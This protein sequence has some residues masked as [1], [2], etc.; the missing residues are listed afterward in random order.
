[1]PTSSAYT[2][3]LSSPFLVFPYLAEGGGGVLFSINDDIAVKTVWNSDNITLEYVEQQKD[4]IAGIKVESEIYNLLSKPENRHPNILLSFL[5][6]PDY[7]FLERLPGSL[8]D[9]MSNPQSLISQKAQHCWILQIT[10]A[11][12]W[13]EMLSRAHCD[14]ARQK[15]APYCIDTSMALKAPYAIHTHSESI[16]ISILDA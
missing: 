13:L 1:M 2:P 3:R 9:R 5:R 14:Q 16:R 11:M 6:D 4:S 12:V 7:I 8:Y 10:N 15:Y